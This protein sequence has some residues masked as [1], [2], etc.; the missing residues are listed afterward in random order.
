MVKKNVVPMGFRFLDLVVVEWLNERRTYALQT[1]M[2]SAT[3]SS[4]T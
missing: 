3:Y 2:T 1:K 4:L